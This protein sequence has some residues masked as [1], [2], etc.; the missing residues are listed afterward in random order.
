[1]KALAVSGSKRSPLFPRVPT[2]AEAGLAGFQGN[3][4]WGLAAPAGLGQLLPDPGAPRGRL[5][6]RITPKKIQSGTYGADR[7]R[8]SLR[9]ALRTYA[10]KEEDPR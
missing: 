8:E 3:L 2:F 6:R 4:W 10:G 1:M 7:L 9:H 5:A